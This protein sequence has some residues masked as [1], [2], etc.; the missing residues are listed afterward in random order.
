MNIHI[1]IRNRARNIGQYTSKQFKMLYKQF[2]VQFQ[3]KYTELARE[4]TRKY[5]M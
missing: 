2:F 4:W 5:A 1:M 3:D